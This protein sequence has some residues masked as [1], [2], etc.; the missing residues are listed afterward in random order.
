MGYSPWVCKQLDT[1]EQLTKPWAGIKVSFIA[2]S[3]KKSACNTGD[4]GSIPGLG[5]SP[6]EWN[7]YPLQYF[8]LENSMVREDNP[9][10]H[11]ESDMTEW[12]T[13]SHNIKKIKDAKHTNKS[14][15]SVCSFQTVLSKCVCVL[16]CV[17]I[18]VTLWTVPGSSVHGSFQARILE[19]A[20]I[21]FS[22]GSFQPKGWTQVSCTLCIVRQM[23]PGKPT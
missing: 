6:R 21:S 22:R 18:F 7:G 9:W 1:T 13:L 2:Q 14:Q 19:Q 20:A 16:S 8:W 23:L 11:T 4:L 12:L 3:V 17:R 15:S 5:R 10:D